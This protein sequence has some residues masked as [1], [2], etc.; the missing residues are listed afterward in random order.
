MAD[1]ILQLKRQHSAEPLSDASI[2]RK[3]PHLSTTDSPSTS[4]PQSVNSTF[5][6]AGTPPADDGT[7]T[8]L[9]NS[10]ASPYKRH[11]GSVSGLD[12]IN[13]APLGPATNESPAQPKPQHATK[14]GTFGTFGQFVQA[15]MEDDEEL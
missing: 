5:A 11:R 14:P 3:S 8:S 2:T 10:V 7:S 9:L 4:T 1:N 12:T 13:F 6:N 15:P